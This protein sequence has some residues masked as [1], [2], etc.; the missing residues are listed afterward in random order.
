MAAQAADASAGDE[1]AVVQLDPL[2]VVAGNLGRKGS[3]VSVS[4]RVL[5][6]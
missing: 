5:K 1:L 6:D 3:R 2:E 4:I